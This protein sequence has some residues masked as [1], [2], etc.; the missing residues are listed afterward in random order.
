MPLQ[1]AALENAMNTSD[2]DKLKAA[3]HKLKSSV[4]TI[5]LTDCLT[6]LNTIEDNVLQKINLDDLPALVNKITHQCKDALNL[7][8]IE[9]VKLSK[10]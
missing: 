2:L 1:I 6:I 9:I 10:S 8:E 4:S 7:L 5:G 3:A